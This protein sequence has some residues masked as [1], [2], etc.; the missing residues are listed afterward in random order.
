MDHHPLHEGELKRGLKNRHI[1]L[2]ALGGAIGTGLFLGSAG[3]MKSAGPS[4]LLGYAI[5]GLIA[6][7][8]MRQLGEMIVS[9]PV[10]GSFSHFAYKY[11]GDLPGFM[12]GWNYWV[13]YILVGMSELTA[14]GKYVQYWW[15]WIP[16]W[17]TAAAFFVIINLVNLANVKMYG[18]AEFWFAIIKV[19]AVIGMIVL[20]GYLLLSGGAGPDATVRNLWERGGFFPNGWTGLAMMLPIIM[21]SFGGLELVGITA[22]EADNPSKTIPKA[23]N[24]VLYRILI[25]YIGALAVLLSLTPWDTLVA[26][27]AQ[28]AAA[29][30]EYGGSPFV[31]VFSLLGSDVAANILNFVVLTAALSVY[32]SCVYCNSRMLYGLAEQGNAPRALM[33]VDDRGVPMLAIGVSALVTGLCVVVNYVIPAKALELLMALV[34]AAL[35]INWAMISLAHLK[36]RTAMQRN[37]ETTAFKAL[38][39]P[40]GNYL[41]LAFVVVILGIMYMIPPLR[42]SVLAIPGWLVLLCICFA[43]KKRRANATA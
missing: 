4:M 21:F 32:N 28:H 12:S 7:L 9:E 27:L 23:I 1:Q 30:D 38:W 36:F 43:L 13:L 2:I 3:V 42:A 34:V 19:V 18:E 15:P 29:G 5:G 25:F 37:G 10:A 33:K 8:I 14:V 40:F 6:F 31:M 35:V 39:Y 41:C 24:Q 16:M 20:G 26:T 17:A 22:A 11:W